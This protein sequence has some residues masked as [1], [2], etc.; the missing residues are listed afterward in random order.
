MISTKDLSAMPSNDG[1]RHLTQSLATLDAVIQKEWEGRYYSFNSKWGVNEQMASMR[2]GEGDSWFCVFAP[3]GAFLKGFD[4]ESR[5][6]PRNNGIGKT[7]PGILDE[8]PDVFKPFLRE[9]A[10]S[11]EET[12]F[13][14]WRTNTDAV[15]HKGSISY[16]EGKD[17]PDGSA[18]LLYIFD[19]NPDTYRRWAERYYKR[20]V[21][22]SLVEHI[23]AHKPLTEGVIRGLNPRASLAELS[24]DLHEIDY[25][26]S[27][28]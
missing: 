20:P 14:I 22:L 19:A 25:P 27:A 9:P 3:F 8:V 23:Y 26:V 7:W 11:M 6:S 12:T 24:G 18:H 17:D 5:M 15:W 28:N 1:L 13:C 2:N 10:F 21:N 16:P 4:H